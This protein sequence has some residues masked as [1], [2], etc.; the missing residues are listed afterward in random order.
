MPQLRDGRFLVERNYRHV[1]KQ[2]MYEFPAGYVE[3]GETPKAAALRELK[4][5]TGY[6]VRKDNTPPGSLLDSRQRDAEAFF[7][8][9]VCGEDRKEAS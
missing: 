4:E 1:L 2:R 3:K 8:S 6:G 5:E 7:L 9:R